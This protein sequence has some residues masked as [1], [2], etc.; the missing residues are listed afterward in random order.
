MLTVLVI[1][2]CF[3]VVLMAGLDGIFYLFALI[4]A[5][6]MLYCGLWALVYMAAVFF[7]Q[8]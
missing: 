6:L 4:V 1:L 3:V 5:S 8:F 7:S 2:G